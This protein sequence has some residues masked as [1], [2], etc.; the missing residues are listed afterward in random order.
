MLLVFGQRF[1]QVGLTG[2]MGT[3]GDALDNAVAE[4]FLASL[5]CEL[6]DW[7]NWHIREELARAMFHYVKVFC[8][9]QVRHSTL[10][11]P[12]AI[13]DEIVNSV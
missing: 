7:H 3:H 12:G 2:S 13:D 8:I 10:T 9:L 11:F 4:S 6:L 1:R 5:R